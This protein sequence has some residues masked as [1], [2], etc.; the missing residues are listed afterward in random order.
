[1]DLA[2]GAG[3][4]LDVSKIPQEL[5]YLI[6]YVEKWG[7]G[8]LEDQ[9]AFVMEMRRQRP[10]EVQEFNSVVDE[11]DPLIRLWGATLSQFDKHISQLTEDDWQHP[12]WSFL[13][14]LKLRE[15]TGCDDKSPD[16]I[17]A[18]ERFARELRLERYAQA[19]TNA[20]EAFRL[21]DYSAYVCILQPFEDLLTPV[22]KKKRDLAARRM[23][24]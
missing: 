24:G 5:H 17:A 20:D 9:D 11:A 1:M 18:D 22:Q 6:P 13:S 4:K 8:S 2:Q 12:Y 14:M 15:I 3:L 19:I 7:F 21:G 23:P 10:K 16:E